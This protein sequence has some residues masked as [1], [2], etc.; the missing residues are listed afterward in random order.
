MLIGICCRPP[1]AIIRLK[2]RPIKMVK[3]GDA[4]KT[5]LLF[6]GPWGILINNAAFFTK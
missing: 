4:V 6:A 2:I 1:R 3:T 5:H